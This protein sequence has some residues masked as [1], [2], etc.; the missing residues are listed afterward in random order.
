MQRRCGHCGRTLT[1]ADFSKEQSRGMEAERKALGLEGVLFRYYVCPAC[2]HADIFVDLHPLP[3]E[4]D[5]AFRRRK[6]ELE[7]A[8]RQLPTE[9]VEVV[10]VP[11]QVSG[12]GF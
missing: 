7:E 12:A 6:E 11:R 8:V 4:D 1:P 10:L 2:Q 9:G 3:G 5:Q